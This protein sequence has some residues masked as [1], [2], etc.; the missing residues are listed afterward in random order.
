MAFW[1]DDAG[2]FVSDF[3]ENA[4]ITKVGFPSFDISVLFDNAEEVYDLQTGQVVSSPPQIRCV[5]TDVE[6]VSIRDVVK[7][8]D[9]TY[10]IIAIVDDKTGHTIF[11]LSEN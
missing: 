2:I 5:S 7:C 9:V 10:Y 6:G 1:K 8:S 4:N 11:Q 3:A